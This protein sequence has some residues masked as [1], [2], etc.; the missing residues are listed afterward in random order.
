MTSHRT[1]HD[2]ATT[3]GTLHMG[4]CHIL[5]ARRRPFA[6]PP[7]DQ[8]RLTGMAKSL[9]VDQQIGLYRSTTAFAGSMHK[10]MLAAAVAGV[11]I[12]AVLWHP[13]PLMIAAFLGIVGLAEQR[14]GPNI[15]AAIAA[16]DSGTSTRGEVTIS[17]SRWDTDNHYHAT[18]REA[19]HA[20]WV[21]EFI[22]M[23]WQP[24][25]HTLQ[26][27]VWRTG[28]ERRPVLAIA[29]EGVMIPRYEPKR[30]KEPT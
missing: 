12:A 11:A 13:V 20:D 4:P 15:V 22:P 16:Y 8:S 30:V 14:A 28:V 26:A 17:I 7:L 3:L 21:Y 24:S 23:G 18:V 25:E 1:F 9:S 27:R 6:L 2:A 10:W 29:E 19:G 5:G